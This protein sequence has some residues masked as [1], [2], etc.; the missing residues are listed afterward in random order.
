ML[1]WDRSSLRART[2]L[3]TSAAAALVCIGVSLLFLIFM[4]SQ[5]TDAVQARVTDDWDRV[6]PVIAL[7]GHLPPVLPDSVL[8]DSKSEAIQV[9]DARGRVVAATRELAGKPPIAT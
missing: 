1:N 7:G 9:L 3:A 6:L 2:V 5:K 4:G 8:A